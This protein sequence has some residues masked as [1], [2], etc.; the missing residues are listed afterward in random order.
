MN[1]AEAQSEYKWEVD[2]H[3]QW[4]EKSPLLSAHAGQK[5]KLWAMG[6]NGSNLILKMR[7]FSCLLRLSLP[8]EMVEMAQ[9][10]YFG[11]RMVSSIKCHTTGL[12]TSTQTMICDLANNY[13][14]HL[15]SPPPATALT[16]K[17]VNRL[18]ELGKNNKPPSPHHQ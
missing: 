15:P 10:F 6:V 12:S 3:K 13:R 7:C 11:N 9:N 4:S 16:S 2:E 5:Q 8:P 14:S 17:A 1:E 18:L